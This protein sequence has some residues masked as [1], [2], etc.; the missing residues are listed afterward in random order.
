MN[1]DEAYTL[2]MGIFLVMVILAL[3]VG[4]FTTIKNK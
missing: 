3:G 1:S 2:A 4:L